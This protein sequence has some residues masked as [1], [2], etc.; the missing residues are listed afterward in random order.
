[1]KTKSFKHMVFASLFGLALSAPALA[2][3]KEEGFYLKGQVGSSTFSGFDAPGGASVNEKKVSDSWTLGAGLQL[4]RF[5]SFQVSRSEFGSRSGRY[6][7]EGEPTQNFSSELSSNALS[8]LPSLMVGDRTRFFVELGEHV[9]ESETEVGN[10]KVF[11]DG[12]DFFYGLGMDYQLNDNMKA[13]FEFSRYD[14][15]SDD[16]RTSG[17]SLSYTF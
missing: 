10:V 6:T 2:E 12:S 14:L 3:V 5:L 15:G 1:M 7:V 13:G 16:F 9:W 8:I 17:V 4:S 11:E